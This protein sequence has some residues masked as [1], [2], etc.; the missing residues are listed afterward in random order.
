M[1]DPDKSARVKKCEKIVHVQFRR[2]LADGTM[3]KPG[4]YTSAMQHKD[5]ILTADGWA[6]DSLP[7]ETTPDYQQGVGNGK[8]NA[9]GSTKA[10]MSDAPTTGGGDKGFFDPIGNPTGWRTYT[11]EFAAFAYCMQGDDCGQWYEGVKW[12][13]TKTW[14]DQRDGKPGLSKIVDQNVGGGPST[15]QREAFTKFNSAKGFVPC[16]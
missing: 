6:V 2:G 8:K 4:T 15:S 7:S 14:Q 13:Y 9:G 1:F 16:S 12:E 10:T 3:I 5:A 11:I